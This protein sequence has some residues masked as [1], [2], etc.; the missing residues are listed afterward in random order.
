M[1]AC[2]LNCRVL[3]TSCTN[4]DSPVGSGAM[5]IYGC[6]QPAAAGTGSPTVASIETSRNRAP[7]QCVRNG[8][9]RRRVNTPWDTIA[10]GGGP[11]SSTIEEREVQGMTW[12]SAKVD[13]GFKAE[14]FPPR[15]VKHA[16]RR[17]GTCIS[18]QWYQMRCTRIPIFR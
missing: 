8:I 17:S 3:N 1:L 9:S 13:Q 16:L 12:R 14:Q 5:G 11:V 15:T 6:A 2:V 7:V 10:C 18:Q 4:A